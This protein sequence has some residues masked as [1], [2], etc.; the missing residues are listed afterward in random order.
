MPGVDTE[1]ILTLLDTTYKAL[2][3]I[4]HNSL[5]AY[6]RMVARFYGTLRT[7]FNYPD[8]SEGGKWQIQMS[9]GLGNVD[10]SPE[11]D[12]DFDDN[13]SLLCF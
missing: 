5:A 9:S 2:L 11:E 4:E 10:T 8:K 7:K 13:V 12:S 3:E 1:P 6:K